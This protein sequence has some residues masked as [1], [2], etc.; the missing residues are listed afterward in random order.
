M[1][2]TRYSH[3][4]VRLEHNGGVLVIDPGEWSEPEALRG[5]DAVLVTHEH[6]DHIDQRR[7]RT[8]GVPVYAPVGAQITGVPFEP[9]MVGSARRIAGMSVQVVG[10]EHAA[11]EGPS[12]CVNVGYVVEGVYHPGDALHRP[13]VTVETL[14]VPMFGSWLKTVEA[15]QFLRDVAPQRAFGIHDGQLNDRGIDSV[16]G[17]FAKSGPYEWLVPRASA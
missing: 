9:V 5:A 12:P 2:L 15:M 10:G 6:F 11:I 1:K 14:L 3:A 4:C 17:W 16:N 13:D 8:A 7:L